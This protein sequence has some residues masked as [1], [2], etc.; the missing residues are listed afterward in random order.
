MLTIG[1]FPIPAALYETFLYTVYGNPKSED[2]STNVLMTQNA[3]TTPALDKN[4]IY[5]NGK[6]SNIYSDES[7]IPVKH[8]AV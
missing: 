5:F 4:V 1:N 8:L 3:G 6:I 7:S 2:Q